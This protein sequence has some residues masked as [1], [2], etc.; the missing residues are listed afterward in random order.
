MTNKG[1][2]FSEFQQPLSLVDVGDPQLGPRQ[3][4]VD[5]AA[6]GLCHSDLGII[7]GSGAAWISQRPIVLGHEV[8]GVISELGAE[9]TDFEIGDRVAV[10]LISHPVGFRGPIA[11]GL[12]RNGGFEQHAVADDIELVKLPDNV[13]MVQGAAATDSVTTAYHAVVTTGAITQGTVVGVIG[14]SG[15]GLNAVQIARNLG[16]VVHAVDINQAA[17]QRALELGATSVHAA[18]TELAP[19]EPEVVLDFAGVGQTTADAVAVVRPGG[20]V[21]LVG[22]GKT[23]ATI[24]TNALILKNV[25]LVGSLGGSKEDLQR[26]LELI[27]TGAIDNVIT[28]VAFH[29]VPDAVDMLS[30]G[31]ITGRLVVRVNPDI[32]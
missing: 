8:A 14:T 15:L 3:V 20:R 16:G 1:W 22:L 11:P 19:F 2:L 30:E 13:S 21:V 26:V 24:S 4:V 17:R 28:E 27:S 31:R 12:S 7:D 29:Q 5:V 18:V 32:T 25:S 9:V 6:A 10:A 23:E